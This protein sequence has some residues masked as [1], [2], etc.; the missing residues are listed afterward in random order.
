MSDA[1]LIEL[2][3]NIWVDN[4]GD[5]AGLLWVVD[6]LKDRIDEIIKE[7]KVNNE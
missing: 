4:G 7:R 5:G 3:A 1:K 2:T 6:D